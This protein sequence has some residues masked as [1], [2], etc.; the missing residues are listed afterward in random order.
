MNFNLQT[1]GYIKKKIRTLEGFHPRIT[2]VTNWIFIF[3]ITK[4]NWFIEH[5][6]DRLDRILL[7]GQ[8]KS[9][10]LSQHRTL[11]ILHVPLRKACWVIPTRLLDHIQ[12]PGLHA[13]R[14]QAQLRKQLPD[15][16]L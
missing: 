9:R 5:T 12:Q 11:D 1:D 7:L 4:G 14:E 2:V 16:E 10:D 6:L 3:C 8:L 13:K 15:N